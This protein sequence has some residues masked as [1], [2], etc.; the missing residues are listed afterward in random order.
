[1]AFTI[2]VDIGGSAIKFAVVDQA[3]SVVWPPG[4]GAMAARRTGWPTACRRSGVARLAWQTSGEVEEFAFKT[5][6]GSS[7]GKDSSKALTEDE[8]IVPAA[9]AQTALRKALA[10]IATDFSGPVAAIGIGAT[11]LIGRD[12]IVREGY[13]FSGYRGTDWAAVAT[14][15]GFRVPVC[16]LNDARAAAWAEYVRVGR[17]STF[18]HVTAGTR[19]GCAI[20]QH[21]RLLEGADS[22]AGEF[23]YQQFIGPDTDRYHA[24]ARLM[25]GLRDDPTAFGAALTGVIHMIN[26]DQIVLRGFAPHFMAAVQAHV[27]RYVFKTHWRSLRGEE[28]EASGS[29]LYVTR[30]D[31]WLGSAMLSAGARQ[32]K[33]SRLIFWTT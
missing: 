14:G 24:G 30:R 19:V 31:G 5:Q 15:A 33:A 10:R 13:A 25:D 6:A 28:Q 11:G 18:L 29:T 7:Y 4:R 8:W 27:D 21:A 26:P 17:S 20:V 23:S 1:M 3:G 22:C 16:V 2:G 12:G 9:V 32:L